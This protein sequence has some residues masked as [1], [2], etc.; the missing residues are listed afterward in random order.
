M[1]Y[2]KNLSVDKILNKENVASWPGASIDF[3][4]FNSKVV[5]PVYCP[6]KEDN[7]IVDYWQ[8]PLDK[9]H[10]FLSGNIAIIQNSCGYFNAARGYCPISVFEEFC[11]ERSYIDFESLPHCCKNLRRSAFVI[12]RVK[13]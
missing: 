2:I 4:W 1:M 3:M 5:P 11:P 6:N 8:K 12:A 9:G 7:C 10:G 13:P